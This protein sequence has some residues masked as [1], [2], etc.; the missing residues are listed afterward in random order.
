MGGSFYQDTRAPQRGIDVETRGPIW[1]SPRR[2]VDALR[3]FIVPY[4]EPRPPT[5]HQTPSFSAP[6]SGTVAM[7]VS[8]DG[9]WRPFGSTRRVLYQSRGPSVAGIEM[10]IGKCINRKVMV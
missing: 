9:V 10:M 5:A 2:L 1:K 3:R 7:A 4:R 8:F 6:M